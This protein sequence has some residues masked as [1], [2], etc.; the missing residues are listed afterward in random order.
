MPAF[1]FAR[2]FKN[3]FYLVVFYGFSWVFAGSYDDF[4]RAVRQD[5]ASTVTALL[6]RG[7]D[8]NTVDPSGWHGLMLAIREPSPRV[9]RVLL[10]WPSIK[11]EVR[12]ASNESPLMLAALAGE[13]ELCRLLIQKNADVNKPGWAAL[14]YA[15]TNGHLEVMNLLL[16]ENAYIDA[17]S[18]NGTT[19]LMMAAHYGTPAAVQLLLQAGAD[20]LLKNM[21]GLA[22][23]DFANRGRREDSANIIRAFIRS[24]QPKGT[25]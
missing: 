1:R 2:F 5:D 14:H 20:P 17:Q 25:W 11:V 12:N 7:F 4:F 9:T 15:A 18:P 21:Q 22:A 24:L 16:E 19:P 23:L 8:P 6:Q 13:L 10:D 3:L